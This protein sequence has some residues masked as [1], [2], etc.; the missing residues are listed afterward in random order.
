VKPS[1]Q[2]F[3]ENVPTVTHLWNIIIIFKILKLSFK[4]FPAI[5]NAREEYFIILLFFND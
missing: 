3:Q 2:M 1:V 5:E 4:K